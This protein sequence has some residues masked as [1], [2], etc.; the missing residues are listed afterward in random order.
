MSKQ[1]KDG[2]AIWNDERYRSMG[3]KLE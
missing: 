1:S 3:R 2:G